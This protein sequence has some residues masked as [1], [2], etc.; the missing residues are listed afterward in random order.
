MA[1]TVISFSS[2]LL[3]A[4]LMFEKKKEKKKMFSR[5]SK[6]TLNMNSG[7]NAAMCCV[8]EPAEQTLHSTGSGLE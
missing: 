8:T 1:I 3:A 4:A 2:R 7:D 6:T 5:R